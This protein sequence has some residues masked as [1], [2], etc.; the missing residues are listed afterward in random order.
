[1]FKSF[2]ISVALT[3]AASTTL[4]PLTA[5]TASASDQNSIPALSANCETPNVS[6]GTIYGA[7]PETPS[8]A[9]VM[10]LT[11]TTYVQV[12]LEA[13]GSIANT[14]VSKSS[15]TPLLDR[16]ALQAARESTFRPEIRGC[17]PVAGS[18]IFVVDFPGD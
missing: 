10:H 1:M 5:T 8:V 4:V 16:A 14:S 3:A 17:A 6:A 15:G 18:Y 7:T 9:R 12:D 2:I 13:D 11:G